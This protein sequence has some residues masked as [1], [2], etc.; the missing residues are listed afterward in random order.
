MSLWL[1]DAEGNTIFVNQT[2]IDWTGRPFEMNLG[3]GWLNAIV[4][5][6]RKYASDNFLKAFEKRKFLEMDF[7]IIRKEG[8]IRWCTATGSPFYNSEGEFEGYAGSL[9]DITE[10]KIAEQ[11]LESQNI[12]ISTITNNTFQGMLMMNDQQVCTYMN[13]AAEQMT[14]YKLAE[15]QDKPLHYYVHHTKPDGSH[16]PIEECPID[17]AL[18]TKS[19]TRG[20]DVFV[21]KDGHFYPVAFVASPIVENGI[22]KGTVIEVRDTTQE[23][24]MQEE[25][26]MQEAKAKEMLELKVKER[27]ADLERSNYE[28]LQFASVASHDLK[29]PLRK[30]SIFSQLLKEKVEGTTDAASDRYLNTIIQS[31]GRMSKLI[32]DLLSFSRLSQ[33]AI[34]FA[35]VD[36]NQLLQDIVH[37]LEIPIAEKNATLEIGSL[38]VVEGIAIQL[39]Q[40]FQNLIANSLKFAHPDRHPFISIHCEHIT[41]EDRPA[42]LLHYSD[43][44]I[45]F[46]QDYADKIFEIFQRLHTKD[47]YEGTGVGL[48]IVKKIVSLHNGTIRAKGKD[49]EGATFEILLPLNR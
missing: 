22:S 3:L 9:V 27:T 25:L 41:F 43:N 20:E 13:P 10:R 31:S 47:K 28:L 23:K 5:E 37:D 2:W 33:T 19:Q 1:S 44:G 12:L 30:I 48:A 21:H 16:F 34:E 35:P 26:R 38:P 6:D 46:K 45:G 40:V 42:C 49:G 7:R 32:D 18:P 39:G 8:E 15:V 14:G 17:R 29:E 11:K 24:Q 36:L 4:A